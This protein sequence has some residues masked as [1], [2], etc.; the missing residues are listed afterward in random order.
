M[1]GQNLTTKHPS[2][3]E[4]YRHGMDRRPMCTTMGFR[5]DVDWSEYNS[6]CMAG[7]RD[8]DS[9]ALMDEMEKHFGEP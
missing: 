3:I 8:A 5:K 9:N 6:G 1:A 4:G 2:W 7:A